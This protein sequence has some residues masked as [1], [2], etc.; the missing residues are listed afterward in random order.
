MGMRVIFLIMGNAGSV[1]SAVV[2]PET[3]IAEDPQTHNPNLKAPKSPELE[4]PS[5]NPTP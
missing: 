2:S 4:T 5:P 3:S 1:S